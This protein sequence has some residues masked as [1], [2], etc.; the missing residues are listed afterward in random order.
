MLVL[1]VLTGMIH[2]FRYYGGTEH[3]DELER[4]C[5]KRALEVFGLDSEKWGVNAQPYSGIKHPKRCRQH[6]VAS[7][8]RITFL[9]SL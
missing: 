5:Q 8:P 6:V 2:H 7:R 3:I 4:L 1:T 9:Y